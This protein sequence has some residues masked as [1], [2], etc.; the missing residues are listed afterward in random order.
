MDEALFFLAFCLLLSI[1]VGLGR[2]F[3]GPTPADQ[4]LAVQL[5]GTGGVA[6]LLVLS[7]TS[8]FGA[9]LDVAV[10]YALLAAVTQIAFVKIHSSISL[11]H[12]KNAD[13]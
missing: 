3:L 5:S 11:P 10:V 13:D 12:G 7:Q 1:G 2:I 6:V 9:L 4:I 8:G